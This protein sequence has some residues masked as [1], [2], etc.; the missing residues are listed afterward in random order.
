MPKEHFNTFTGAQKGLTIIGKYAYAYSGDVPVNQPE[1]TLLLFQSPKDII[2][3]WVTVTKNT[4]D[5]DDFIYRL[6]FNNIIVQ[7]W[8]NDYS[9]GG[10]NDDTSIPVIIPPL[11]E[12]KLTA[13]NDTGTTDRNINGSITG[14][15]YT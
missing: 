15:V 12:V 7:G 11:T 2:K 14:K 13:Y 10:R 6:Y 3:G 1:G 9:A 4:T 8:I 5:G